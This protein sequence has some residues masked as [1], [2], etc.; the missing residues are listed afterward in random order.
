ML[1][2]NNDLW[3]CTVHAV[4]ANKSIWWT[5]KDLQMDIYEVVHGLKYWDHRFTKYRQ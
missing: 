5:T 4:C 1:V 3:I 2:Q